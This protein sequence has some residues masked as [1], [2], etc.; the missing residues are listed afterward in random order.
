M[1]GAGSAPP[2]QDRDRVRASV[3]MTASG[4]HDTNRYDL[5]VK[6]AHGTAV[7]D[8]T[9]THLFWNPATK[10]WTKAVALGHGS[11]LH[12]RGGARAAVLGGYAPRSRTGWMWDLS[13]TADHDFYV[14]VAATT[15]VLVHNCAAEA[16][17]AKVAE[18]QGAMTDAEASRTTYAAAHVTTAEGNEEM[19]VAA[20]ASLDMCVL[21]SVAK[22]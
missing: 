9:T 2:G 15:A 17:Q 11:Y 19:W 1:A 12:M 22:P 20:L 8:T 16:V 3:V 13:V 14:N 21:R 6:T 4:P 18:M 10:R 7:I 5:T